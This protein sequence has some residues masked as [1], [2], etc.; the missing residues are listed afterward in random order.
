VRANTFTSGN[1]RSPSVASSA[2]AFVVVWQSPQNGTPDVFGQRFSTAALPKRLG[3]NF[4]VNS[5]V[6]GTQGYPAV[7]MDGSGNFVVVYQSSLASVE[8]DVN[9]QRFNSTGTRLGA[10]FRVNTFTSVA[11]TY[12]YVSIPSVSSDPS[13][14]FVVVWASASGGNYTIHGQRYSSAG[15]MVGGDFRVNSNTTFIT[16]RNPSV[17]SASDGSFVVVWDALAAASSYDVWARR[18]DA[19]GAPL[20]DD[21]LV[22]AYTTNLQHRPSV[23]SDGSGNFVVVW[24]SENQEVAS[25]HV[26]ARRYA[27]SGAALGPELRVDTSGAVSNDNPR[28]ASDSSGNLT[29]V[30]Q[31]LDGSDT[32]VFGRRYLASGAPLGPVFLVNSYTTLTQGVPEV[33]ASG[34]GFVVTWEAAGAPFTSIILKRFPGQGDVDGSGATDVG[35]VFYLIN[36]LFAGGPAPLGPADVNGDGATDV[37]DVFYL[38]NFLFAGGPAPL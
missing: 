38:I 22:N 33:A 26:Y 30:W 4:R 5:F 11:V 14:N 1:M 13:G 37:A 21:F 31:S 20:G 2:D 32:G 24:A 27:T 35:D 12:A 16:Q 28:V 18:F 6:T 23:A 36:Y 29:V 8:I 10:E 7:A 9:G 3:N 15:A 34:A 19:N 25:Y 17:S